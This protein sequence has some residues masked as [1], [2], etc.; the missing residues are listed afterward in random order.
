FCDYRGEGVAY[1]TA[2]TRTERPV[3]VVRLHTPL[4]VLFRYNTGHARQRVLE[5]YE[6]EAIRAADRIVSPSRALADEIRQATGDDLSIDI[7]P[8]PVDPRFLECDISADD[9][10]GDEILYVGRFEERKGV[11]TLARA[12]GAFLRELSD[13]RL[14][15]IGGDTNK[16]AA[17]PS[18]R[19][20]VEAL[21][22]RAL[23]GRVEFIDRLPREEL[24]EHYRRARICV[25]PS[26]FE[27]FPNTCLEAMALGRCTIGTTRS[28]MAEMIEDGVSGVVAPAQDADALSAAIVN[29]WRFPPERR[30]AMGE[31][32]RERIRSR[33]HPDVVAGELERLYGGYLES[34][35]RRASMPRAVWRERRPRVAVVIPCY[36]HGA[37]LREAI[38]SV[39]AQSYDRVECVV[40]NDGSTDPATL[41]ALAEAEREGARVIHQENAGLAAARNAGVRATD[42][43]FF[44]PLDADDRIEPEFVESLLQPLLDEPALGYCYSHVRF[45]GDASGGWE[46]PPYD[47]RKLLIENVSTATAVV[48]RRAFDEV[49]GY[50]P[51]MIYGFEDWDFWIALLGAGYH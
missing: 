24:F 18:M 1:L 46:C 16:S 27:N 21:I 25:F 31:A 47:P 20:V 7:S 3:S 51:D 50:Q 17:E 43:S 6:H 26:H 40:V 14:V 45:F 19:K 29:V 41:K 32:A 36:N 11:E 49:G 15:M 13:A 39:R 8:H 30:R 38:E 33:Y 10:D 48:R 28:G 37:F 5:E 23:R 2:T 34:H 4:S 35:P 12:A 42:A 22:P 44:A 9:Y